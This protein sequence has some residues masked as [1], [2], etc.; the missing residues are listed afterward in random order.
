[1][2]SDHPG[3][4][5]GMAFPARGKASAQNVMGIMG[6]LQKRCKRR[7]VS[8]HLS[9][10]GIFWVTDISSRCFRSFAQTGEE[11]LTNRNIDAFPRVLSSYKEH[12]SSRVILAVPY[13]ILHGHLISNSTY[14][15]PLVLA[16]PCHASVTFAN[17]PP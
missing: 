9:R 11:T 7:S 17:D 5:Q 6:E 10:R 1:M 16:I 12:V 14:L 3:F 8:S 15:Y 4:G 13:P 2:K